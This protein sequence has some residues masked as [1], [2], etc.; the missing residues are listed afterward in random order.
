MGPRLRKD[1]PPL[2][3]RSQS[4]QWES[5]PSVLDPLAPLSLHPSAHIV[6][7]FG[8]ALSC[9][10]PKLPLRDH[11]IWAVAAKMSAYTLSAGLVHSHG[12]CTKG[13]W[14][15]CNA[16]LPLSCLFRPKPLPSSPAQAHTTEAS[17]A[18]RLGPR[19]CKDEPPLLQRSQPIQWGSIPSVL[20]PLA[21]LSL[22][23]SA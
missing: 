10:L 7:K 17:L 8:P 6:K 13:Y 16:S 5:I 21:P 14:W 1:G 15:V 9:K 4:I 11:Y 19:L 22:P 2:L 20:D 18:W 12:R 23:P 3:H